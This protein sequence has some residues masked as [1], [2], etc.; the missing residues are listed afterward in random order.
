MTVFVKN[1][2]LETIWRFGARR[3]AAMQ[4]LV[5]IVGVARV[6]A[7]IVPILLPLLALHEFQ[8]PDASALF[9]MQG[10]GHWRG[11]PFFGLTY[12]LPGRRPFF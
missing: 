6:I 12:R 5:H 8:Q 11:I 3:H 9:G 4:E 1:Q 10:Y 2:A 7:A